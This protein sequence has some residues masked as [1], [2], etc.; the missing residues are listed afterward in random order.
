VALDPPILVL[1]TGL[2]PVWVVIRRARMMAVLISEPAEIGTC[3]KENAVQ[4]GKW[5]IFRVF[6]VI[7]RTV[8]KG[9]RVQPIFQVQF[10]VLESSSC[11]SSDIGSSI[12]IS[13]FLTERGHL[14][15]LLHG[16]QHVLK[17]FQSSING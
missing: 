2:A 15:E 9:P 13:Q 11:A 8:P 17:R 6:T 14:L 10:E 12:A 16:Q 4:S 1:V 7:F 3:Q 5:A